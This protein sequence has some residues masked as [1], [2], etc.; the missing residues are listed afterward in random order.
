MNLKT[1]RNEIKIHVTSEDGNYSNEYTLIVN[2]AHSTFLKSLELSDYLLTPEFNPETLEYHVS[3]LSHTMSL[4]V[5]A[6]PYDEEASIKV[7]GLGYIK[8]NT[9]GK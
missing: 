9:T 4:S 1:G 8:G 7:E 6:K 2:R 3:V 5:N